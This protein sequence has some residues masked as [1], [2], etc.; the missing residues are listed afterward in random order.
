M[1]TLY[2][3]YNAVTQNHYLN[4]LA[5]QIVIIHINTEF[6]GAFQFFHQVLILSSKIITYSI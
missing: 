3:L 1:F 6:V 5:D 4:E 2:Y